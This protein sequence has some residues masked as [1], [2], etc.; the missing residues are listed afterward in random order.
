MARS[1]N[2]E[3]QRHVANAFCALAETHAPKTWMIQSGIM[4][5]LFRLVRGGNPE[6]QLAAAQALLYMR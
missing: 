2:E 6:V 5:H 1:R 4:P 3:L